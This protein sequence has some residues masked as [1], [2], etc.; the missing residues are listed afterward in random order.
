MDDDFGYLQ[1]LRDR[2]GTFVL[3]TERRPSRSYVVLHRTSCPTIS[4][5]TKT[6]GWTTRMLKVCATTFE[7]LESWCQYQ[8][9]A[10]PTHCPQC[11]PTS[12]LPSASAARAVGDRPRVATSPS[13][14]PSVEGHEAEAGADA[15]TGEV[16][17]AAAAPPRASRRAATG[18]RKAAATATAAAPVKAPAAA[19]GRSRAKA[20][21]ATAE[22]AEPEP[23]APARGRAAGA[24]KAKS[25]S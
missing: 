3:D 6:G 14:E 12:N 23:P 25:R 2:P 16:E 15:E 17:A 18:T 20:V 19:S 8:V 1:W 22:H 13:E 4:G 7:E 21:A 9:G 11:K 24:K 5:P 10:D